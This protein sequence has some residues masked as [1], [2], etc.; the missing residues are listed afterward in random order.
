M[1]CK[2]CGQMN[3]DS[4]VFCVKCGTSMLNPDSQDKTVLLNQNQNNAGGPVSSRNNQ[5][6]YQQ[7]QKIPQHNQN[8]NYF[9]QAPPQYA[10]PQ[11]KQANLN[12]QSQQNNNSA[13]NGANKSKLGK[14]QRIIIIVV[15]VAVVIAGFTYGIAKS[16]QQ[17]RAEEAVDEVPLP[18]IPEFDSDLGIYDEG[19]ASSEGSANSNLSLSSTFS[20]VDAQNVY[21]LNLNSYGLNLK[22]P[23]TD[24]RFYE[25]PE[26][27]DFF[28]G[29][30]DGIVYD[31]SSGNVYATID[32]EK[33]YYD[34]L[35]VNE[36]NSQNIQLQIY[37]SELI[38]NYS[39]TELL[40]TL[41]DTLGS[42]YNVSSIENNGTVV[43]GDYIFYVN[44]YNIDYSGIEL[45][46]ILACAKTG[47]YF[48]V[49]A[50]SG[51]FDDSI[52]FLEQM[53]AE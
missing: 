31:E 46:Q 20:Y 21:H 17:S 12:N 28:G 25:K 44:S 14:T 16:V 9:N 22:L 19:E 11:F 4:A 23:N 3:S 1:I 6:T 27:Y 37:N 7:N 41:E 30:E 45:N 50:A 52:G 34:M 2:N 5:Y 8:F 43:L 13:F 49:I 18:E 33:I 40:D 39:E 36:V 47:N 24:W 15:C 35:M 29:A 51:I 32:S 48:I 10:S 38:S 53:V 26:I 42:S